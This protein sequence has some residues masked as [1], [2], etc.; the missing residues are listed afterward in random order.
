MNLTKLLEF[1]IIQQEDVEMPGTAR[2]DLLLSPTT[3]GTFRGEGPEGQRISG[4]LLPVGIG[5]TYSRGP[6]NDIRSLTLLRTED[7]ADILMRMEAVFDVDPQTEAK[8]IA[9]EAVD[10]D[11]YYY[12][13]RVIFETGAAKYKWLERK[14]CISECVI[15]DYTKLQITVYMVE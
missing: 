13:G 1:E 9:G 2:G 5:T 12:K 7:G 11:S 10:P 15:E 14:L 3:G 8:L 4:E 6:E